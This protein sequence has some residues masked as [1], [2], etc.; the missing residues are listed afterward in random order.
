MDT[1]YFILSD[2]HSFYDEM[3]DALNVAGFDLTD[4]THQLIICG[5]LFDRGPKSIECYEFVKSLSEEGRLI[6]I[7]G[8]HEDLLEDAVFE[9]TKGLHVGSHHISNGTIKTIAHFMEC[10]EYDILCGVYSPSK[11]NKKIGELLNFINTHSVDY[12]EVEPFVFVHGWVPEVLDDHLGSIV[13]ADWRNRNWKEARW[14]NGMDAWYLGLNPPEN[15]RT[16][17]CGHWHTSYGWSHLRGKGSEFKH[18][19]IFKPFIEEGLV[20]LDSC[21]AFSHFLNCLVLEFRNNK[22]VLNTESTKPEDN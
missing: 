10:S 13:P 21:V 19:A 5:D 4:Q 8:N 17:V 9:L 6:Y 20:A 7:R 15:D 3:L 12:F 11:F 1:K 14:V 18:D 16:I 2:V 22:W